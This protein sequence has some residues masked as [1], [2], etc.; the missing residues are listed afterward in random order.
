M[1]VGLGAAGTLGIGFEALGDVGT[2][3]VPTKFIPIEN[4]TLTFDQEIKKRRPLRGIVD[5]EGS[6]LGNGAVS[7]DITFAAYYDVI[8]YILYAMRTDVTKT[9]VA[10][11]WTYEADGAHTA[12]GA[13]SLSITVVRNGVAFGYV[14]CYVSALKWTIE[15]GILMCTASIVGFDEASQAVPTPAFSSEGKEY[16]AGQYEIEYADV[17][18]STVDGV[19]ISI[20]DSASAEYRI[21]G[22]TGADLIVF[23]ER[24]TT[25]SLTRD[26]ES[27]AEYDLFRATTAQKW[28]FIATSGVFVLTILIPVAVVGSYE[29]P[30]SGQ[31]DLVRATIEYEGDYD[32]TIGASYRIT[33]LSDSD[34]TVPT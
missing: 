22:T 28:E 10:S 31:G 15:D 3:V 33:A 19:D 6:S 4:E 11:P 23:G 26:F 21:A 7:G 20:D 29:V 5:A 1:T 9:G 16:F 24:T 27:R 14:G 17:V 30:L 34:I 2:Y 32:P 25:V 8:P 12:E 18:V 13:Y